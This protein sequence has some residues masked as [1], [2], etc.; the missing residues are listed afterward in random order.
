M[1]GEIH[2][3]AEA[4]ANAETSFVVGLRPQ[5]AIAASL[6]D[7]LELLTRRHGDA[8]SIA[9]SDEAVDLGRP[10]TEL[11]AA[12]RSPRSDEGDSSWVKRTN[13]V[14]IN[15]RT[16][17]DFGGVVKYALTLPAST[18]SVHL[19]PVWEPGVVKS[20]YGIAS[21]NLN[22]EF[23]S[24]ELREYSPILDTVEKQMRATSNLLHVM[25][26]TIGM[27]VIPHTDRFSEAAL[28][29]PDFFEWMRIRDRRIVDH[30]DGLVRTVEEA[31]FAWIVDRGP[32]IEGDTVPESV[33][34]L[35]RLDETTRLRL[36]FGDEDS[37]SE[38]TDRR[39]DLIMHLK[40][41]GLEPVPA[42]MGVPFRGIEIDPD[43]AHTAIDHHGME[44]PDFV[45]SEPEYM[46]RVFSPLARFKLYERFDDN[47]DW[48]IDFGRPRTEVWD[49]IRRHY[50]ETQHIGNF[51]F[52]RG[53]MS[54]VQMRPDGVP[55]VV[56]EYYDI[57][58]AV[59]THIQSVASAPWFGYFAET[60]LPARDVFQF[61]EELDHLEASLAD[62]T[63]G[64]LQSTVVGD[65]E[66]LRRFR[67]YLD[68]LATRRTAPA[69][70]TMTADKDDPRFDE[71]YREGNEARLFTALLL[72][73]MPTY[74]G[75][76]FE[77]RDVHW[78][79]V[80]NERYTKLFVF[81]E[82]GDSNVYPSKAR[83]GDDFIW[84]R[85]DELFA[86]VTDLRVFAESVLP[87]IGGSTTRWLIPP[88]ATTLRGVAAWTQD[89][90]TL[91]E[92]A[93]RF[94]FVVN[95][96]LTSDSGYFGIPALPID[97]TLEPV[98][99]TRGNDQLPRDILRHG[100]FFHRLENLAPGEG[101]AY[102]IKMIEDRA[103]RHQSP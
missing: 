5:D 10:L 30:S 77:I 79:P 75:L 18:D 99:S 32:A 37:V 73:D 53:D 64:D 35:F 51:D 2:P 31:V 91:P 28:C 39:V 40:W 87:G 98:F 38:R 83:F 23:F 82:E 97:V 41:F 84:G 59:K 20:L 80:E 72:P 65:H 68:D 48:E 101:R 49:Y 33:E 42:T 17:G 81:H 21:W 61:G 103:V 89:P 12:V 9:L 95:Y 54:H 76:G 92:D 26:K 58:A 86:R 57:L 11:P 25:G 62:A 3:A 14:G 78:E 55:A 22:S 13:M 102:R 63:L 47:A 56:D 29:T 74:T 50:A 70:T 34:Q 15:V 1:T 94:V 46:S 66:Y 36:L 52:M 45:M 96:D 67:R 44:W 100:G 93:D 6:S 69:Y 60:F 88:D 90:A 27:D 85:N 43:P 24:D 16:V 19:L 8:V 4:Y 71:M 7:V